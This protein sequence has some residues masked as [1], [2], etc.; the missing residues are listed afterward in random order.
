MSTSAPLQC[1]DP[2]LDEGEEVEAKWT[3]NF[4]YN[5][6]VLEKTTNGYLVHYYE[7][8]DT[9][10][11][12]P[13][14]HIKRKVA[15]GIQQVAVSPVTVTT[16]TSVVH[17]QPFVKEDPDPLREWLKEL[18]LEKYYQSF[19]DQEYDYN[20]ILTFDT[21]GIEEMLNELG[22]KKG[23]KVKIRND[24]M[25]R[26]E[27]NEKSKALEKWLESIGLQKYLDVFEKN[28][29]ADL[30][31]IQ[32][33]DHSQVEKMI[34]DLNMKAGSSI[35]L[36]NGLEITSTCSIVPDQ[37][38]D[39]SDE[40]LEWLKTLKLEKYYKAFKE[41]E[42]DY[43]SILEYSPTEIDDMLN[44]IGIKAGSKIKMKNDLN[45][46]IGSTEQKED[47]DE[48]EV[49][50]WLK[51]IEL[52]KYA[53]QFKDNEYQSLEMI[54]SFNLDQIEE[55]ISTTGIKAGSAIKLKNALKEHNANESDEEQ[56][57]K[58]LND[59]NENHSA[60][61]ILNNE[62]MDS[63]WTPEKN[64]LAHLDKTNDF[65]RPDMSCSVRD[66]CARIKENRDNICHQLPK[67]F[68]VK[69]SR[70]QTYFKIKIQQ[71]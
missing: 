65:A 55:M 70:Y 51:S 48:D 49:T 54:R 40:L 1:E 2:I 36:R 5:A 22:I 53:K 39:Q 28:G 12:I 18:S 63:N 31:K 50:Q 60:N 52:G 14:S 21:E 4:W 64:N 30:E 43:K 67:E 27:L 3:D 66:T 10:L 23:S 25:K 29:Y 19:K 58:P 6:S 68:Y 44:V 13:Y 46:R 61:W 41:N 16:T 34:E 33:F 9:Q 62:A 11:D 24:L 15:D 17:P 20:M 47:E 26:I 45:K 8:G 42:F 57:Y 38:I 56:P 37:T 71:L 7:F 32:G 69:S 59:E 35:K